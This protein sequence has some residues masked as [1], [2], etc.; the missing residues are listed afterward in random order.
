MTIY[1][2][3]YIN[4]TDKGSINILNSLSLSLSL[5][6]SYKRERKI[7]SS[8]V[9]RILTLNESHTINILVELH[10]LTESRRWKMKSNTCLTQNIQFLAP[11]KSEDKDDKIIFCHS[12]TENSPCFPL[13]LEIFLQISVDTVITRDYGYFES[14]QLIYFTWWFVDYVRK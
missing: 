1:S 6:T 10:V 14:L 7:S 4:K 8:I 9:L 5:C 13:Q 2:I 11:C 3:V 12:S